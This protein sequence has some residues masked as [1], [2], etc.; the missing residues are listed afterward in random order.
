MGRGGIMGGGPVTVATKSKA[1]GMGV[2][3]RG[4]RSEG[5]GD[6][7]FTAIKEDGC[8]AGMRS[9]ALGH[10]ARTGATGG[11]GGCEGVGMGARRRRQG[12]EA[13]VNWPREESGE[14]TTSKRKENMTRL[15]RAKG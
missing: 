12:A 4:D 15:T 1:R 9:R 2:G 11:A 6:G 14:L 10:E 13:F 8:A 3:E 5:G 7:E